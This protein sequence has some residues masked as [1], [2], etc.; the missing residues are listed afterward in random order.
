MFDEERE[1]VER[2]LDG[3]EAAQTPDGARQL[4]L[5]CGVQLNI[6]LPEDAPDLYAEAVVMPLP[7]E[8]S[9]PEH[10]R[11]LAS[12]NFF[13][14]ELEGFVVALRDGVLMAEAR[15]D[16]ARLGDEEAL[17]AWLSRADKAVVTIRE[18]ATAP[19][20]NGDDSR[21]ET[22]QGEEVTLWP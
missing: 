22:A 7:D 15:E 14:N 8:A 12:L 3:L 1:E 5:P 20:A 9:S 2:L 16:L 6:M 21:E 17:R 10:C 18:V 11:E 13:W 19:T 4:T